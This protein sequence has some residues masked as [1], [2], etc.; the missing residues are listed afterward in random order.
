MTAS[1]A[2]AD[3]GPC[4]PP[5]PPVVPQN[6]ALLKAYADIIE[7]DFQTYFDALTDFSKCHDQLFARTL[8][9]ARDVSAD[10]HAFLEWAADAGAAIVPRP[11]PDA[12]PSIQRQE[13]GRLDFR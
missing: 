5:V 11:V 3:D 6:D 4:I 2:A 10:Y 13:T 1:Q 7:L 12:S 9:E 8:Q